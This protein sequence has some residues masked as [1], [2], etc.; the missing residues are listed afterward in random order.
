MSREDLELAQSLARQL[1]DNWETVDEVKA[2][3]ET[4]YS[5]HRLRRIFCMAE[6]HGLVSVRFARVGV[7]DKLKALYRRRAYGGRE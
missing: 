3:V 6:T 4:P 2:R 7:Q 5:V 1:T